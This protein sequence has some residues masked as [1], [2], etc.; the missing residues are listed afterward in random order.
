MAFFDHG[1]KGLDRVPERCRN[2]RGM[3]YGKKILLHE[4]RLPDSFGKAHCRRVDS[5][6]FVCLKLHGKDEARGGK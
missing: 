4:V 6:K 5:N 1:P 2:L 3:S